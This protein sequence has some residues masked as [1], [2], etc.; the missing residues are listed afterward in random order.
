MYV[1]F[2]DT[3]KK[4]TSLEP[5]H[6]I[7]CFIQLFFFR[8]LAIWISPGGVMQGT[9]PSSLTS[10]LIMTIMYSCTYRKNQ[11][12]YWFFKSQDQNLFHC[13]TL[14]FWTGGNLSWKSRTVSDIWKFLK[15]TLLWIVSH[16]NNPQILPK[17]SIFVLLIDNWHC[18]CHCQLQ[19]STSL[20]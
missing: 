18:H 4:E 19:A 8:L 6:M 11:I 3:T 12:I 1:I 20:S 5:V 7:H 9:V 17:S 13:S 15:M 16:F 10:P 14:S 2:S